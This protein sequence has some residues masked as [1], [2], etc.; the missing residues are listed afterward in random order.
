M[1]YTFIAERCS[2]LPIS[3]CCRVMGLSMSGFYQRRRQPV[4]DSE[5]ATLGQLAGG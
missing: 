1:I 5:L 4:T 2:D 3:T